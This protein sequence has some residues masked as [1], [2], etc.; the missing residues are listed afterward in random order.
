MRNVDIKQYATKKRKGQRQNQR[1]I[2]KNLEMNENTNISFQ[3]LWHAEK[4][5]SKRE[6]NG[7]TSLPLETRKI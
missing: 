7:G 5:V 3:N 4:D 6:F 1:R 2:F